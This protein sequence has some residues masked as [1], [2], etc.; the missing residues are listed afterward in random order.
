MEHTIEVPHGGDIL[1]FTGRT[2][3]EAWQAAVDFYSAPAEAVE[4]IASTVRV[5]YV[6][7]SDIEEEGWRIVADRPDLSPEIAEEMKMVPWRQ[8]AH[9][10]SEDRFDLWAT[11]TYPSTGEYRSRRD[12]VEQ[13]AVIMNRTI[14]ALKLRETEKRQAFI[15]GFSA[16]YQETPYAEPLR[17]WD[18]DL[19]RHLVF[20]PPGRD[21]QTAD[22]AERSEGTAGKEPG[23][24]RGNPLPFRRRLP[25]RSGRRYRRP[26]GRRQDAGRRCRRPPVC[27]GGLGDAAGACPHRRG[28]GALQ[29]DRQT[30]RHYP[31]PLTLT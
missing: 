7:S 31:S 1:T 8:V 3:D 29:A 4:E 13:E 30:G 14:V 16:G 22:R 6:P 2:A 5:V 15:S 11:R 17:S 27:G 18:N 19:R 10:G 21:Q 12:R 25:G 26:G 24:R 23:T 28:P 20:R 9:W